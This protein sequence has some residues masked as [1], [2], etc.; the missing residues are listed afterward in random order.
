MHLSLLP[1]FYLDSKV[2]ADIRRPSLIFF[3]VTQFLSLLSHVR[4]YRVNPIIIPSSTVFLLFILF[5]CLSASLFMRY[6]YLYSLFSSSI[7]LLIPLK[8]FTPISHWYFSLLFRAFNST[9][10]VVL[11]FF[12]ISFRKF[13]N[14]MISSFGLFNKIVYPVTPLD[15]LFEMKNR[16]KISSSPTQ[17]E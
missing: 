17:S 4:V 3:H 11:F 10:R 14:A 12:S 16:L 13:L 1:V 7:I 5:P 2:D 9:V 6:C 8:C 15:G